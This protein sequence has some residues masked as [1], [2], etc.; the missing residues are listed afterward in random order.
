MLTAKISIVE[1][2]SNNVLDTPS[3][4]FALIQKSVF[5]CTFYKLIHVKQH[6]LKRQF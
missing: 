4:L 2:V 3:L 5:T 6:E 1:I